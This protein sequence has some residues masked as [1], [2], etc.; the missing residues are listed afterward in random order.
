MVLY[1]VVIAIVAAAAIFTGIDVF[2]A[3]K[4]AKAVDIREKTNIEGND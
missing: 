4:T 2:I 3:L 1:A